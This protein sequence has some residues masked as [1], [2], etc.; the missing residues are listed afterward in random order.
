MLA[1]N[2]WVGVLLLNFELF[3]CRNDKVLFYRS[4]ASNDFGQ[5]VTSRSFFWHLFITQGDMGIWD[6]V[7]KN[8][9]RKFCGRQ[10]FKNLLSPL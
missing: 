4:H 10:P 5:S 9:L 3:K 8:E 6:K 7:F 2:D 1:G